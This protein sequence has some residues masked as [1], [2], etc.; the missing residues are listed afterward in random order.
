M[1]LSCNNITKAFGTDV[2][3]DNVS[4]HLNENEKCAIVGINGA[5]K[6]T[7]LK[8]IAGEMS[9][10]SGQVIMSKETTLGYLAQQQDLDPSKTIYD[11]VM[12]VKAGV[13][14]LETNLRRTE[15]MMKDA[16]GDEL[17]NLYKQYDRLNHQFESENGYA[18]RS[19]VTGVI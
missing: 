2:I 14:A 6:S 7:L 12:S 13:L 15:S 17:E 16:S 10:D 9:A 19:E 5:G 1:V 4:F 11:E 3:L 18:I 8:I